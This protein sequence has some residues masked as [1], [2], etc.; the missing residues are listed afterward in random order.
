MDETDLFQME[1]LNMGS[2]EH[3]MN[4]TEMVCLCA[5]RLVLGCNSDHNIS[6]RLNASSISFSICIE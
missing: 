4:N 2:V 5:L 6:E 3:H 1:L